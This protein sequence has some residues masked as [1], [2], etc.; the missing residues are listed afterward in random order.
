MGISNFISWN[1]VSAFH[2]GALFPFYF[3]I[4]FI[5]SFIFVFLFV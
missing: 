2:I 1:L 4:L 5:Y 3:P